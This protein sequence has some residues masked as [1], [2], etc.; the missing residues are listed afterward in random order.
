MTLLA[1]PAGRGFRR[2]MLLITVALAG[3]CQ[4]A[5]VARTQAAPTAASSPRTVTAQHGMVVSAS[6]IA[7]AAGRDVLVAGGNAVDAALADV[8]VISILER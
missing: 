1:V 2:A 4:S 7:S 5:T 3:V 6:S 8:R